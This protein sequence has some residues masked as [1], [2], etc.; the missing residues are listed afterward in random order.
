MSSHNGLSDTQPIPIPQQKPQTSNTTNPPPYHTGRPSQY[1]ANSQNPSPHSQNRPQSGQNSTQNSAQRANSGTRPPQSAANQPYRGTRPSLNGVQPPQNRPNSSQSSGQRPYQGNRPTLNGVY[2][3]QNRQNP[4]SNS[5]QRPVSGR[6]PSHNIVNHPY[7]SENPQEH[8][9]SEEY[10]EEYYEPEPLIRPTFGFQDDADGGNGLGQEYY[11]PYDPDEE[12]EEP[13][14]RA[15]KPKKTRKKHRFGCL[16]RLIRFALTVAFVIFVLYSIVSV[17]CIRK[18]KYV[19]TPARNLT[20][21]IAEADP[22][23]RNILLISSDN[24]FDENGRAD[25][26]VLVS[27][28]RINHTV[29]LTSF[30]RNAYVS[31]P[32]H[33]LG[34]LSSA[35]AYGGASMLMDTIVN[36]FGIQIDDYICLN[37]K[38]IIGL[39]D[40]VGGLK[41]EITDTEAAAINQILRD[42]INPAMGA[43]PEEDFLPSGGIFLLNGKQALAYSRILLAGSADSEHT[44]RQS[45]LLSQFLKKLRWVR[46]SSMSS[47]LKNAAPELTTNITGFQLYLLSLRMPPAL[48]FSDMQTLRLP[49]EGTYSES[50]GADGQKILAFDPDKNYSAYQN[51]VKEPPAQ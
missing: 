2:S 35:Y 40:A 25:L 45:V 30:L 23:V 15:K 4:P 17:L 43:A 21:D 42:T 41:I 51:A 19:E 14:K 9:Y 50:Y 34:P 44:D 31:I 16:R 48:V 1:Y 36:N 38:A 27:M 39:A 7:H 22:K 18:I 11:D 49:A 10:D 12:E 26:M 29:T 32:G 8:P 6:I 28:S 47:V 20:S 37:F 3:P 46:P 5:N 33:G 13:P 24:I